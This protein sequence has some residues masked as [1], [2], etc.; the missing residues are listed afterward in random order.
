[1]FKWGLL[2]VVFMPALLGLFTARKRRERAGL[3]FLLACVFA[4]DCL[5][6]VL[7]YYLRHRWVG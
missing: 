2:S 6:L 1:M 3:S 7:L 4:Y 5:Y